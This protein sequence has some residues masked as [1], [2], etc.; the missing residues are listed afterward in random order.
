MVLPTHAHIGDNQTDK[1]G[2]FNARL[3]DLEN[4]L[5]SV[6]TLDV[7]SSNAYTVTKKEYYNNCVFKIDD[8]AGATGTITIT[9]P[10]GS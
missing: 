6:V 9:A 2:A 5:S 8:A 10:A 7:T 1:E 3:A 4:V